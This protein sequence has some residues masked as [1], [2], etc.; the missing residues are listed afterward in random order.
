MYKRLAKSI[1]LFLARFS[2]VL[3]IVAPLFFTKGYL[4]FTDLVWG[5]NITLNWSNS[6]F[7]LNSVIKG[8]SFILSV[9]LIEKIYITLCLGLVL[10]GGRKIA[11]LF[12]KNQWL[13]FIASLFAFFNPFVYDRAM[14]GQINIVGA[15]GLMLLGAGFLFEY[16]AVSSTRHSKTLPVIPAKAGTRDA[17]PFPLDPGF[18]RDDKM[19]TE[20]DGEKSIKQIFFAGLAFAFS[21][22]FS[23]HFIFFIAAFYILVFLPMFFVG[24]HGSSVGI[25]PERSRRT[26]DDKKGMFTEIIKISVIIAVI[27][28][29][30]NANWIIG[31][32]TGKSA[33]GEFI[34]SGITTQ[35]LVAFQT[36][37]KTG[38]DAL[39]NVLMMSGF[40]GKDQFRYAD[41]TAFA[42]NWGRSFFFLLPLVLWGFVAGLRSKEKKYKYL[43]VGS[44]VLFVVSVILAAGIR[45]PVGRELTYFLFNHLPFYK[46]LRESQKWVSATA[47]IYLIFLSLGLRELFSKKF[48]QRH[49][50]V[51]KCFIGAVIV[52]QAPL[53]L[54]GFGGQ[55]TPVQY[56]NDWYAVNDY[57]VH[58][59]GCAGTTLFFPWH[60]YMSFSW[61]GRI[62]ANPAPV[63]FQCPV[64]SGTDMEFGGI[65]DN[66]E[67]PEGRAVVAWLGAGG[68]TDLLQNS[69]WNIRYV[70]LAKELD[71]KSYVGMDF[72]PALKLVMDT[73]TLRVYKVTP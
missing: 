34:S 70:I 52:M 58:D 33:M 4:F 5:P 9:D 2:P 48:I 16:L 46:G 55:V 73:A 45:I 24:K 57:I 62:V 13:V 15:F 56:P 38:A 40:W 44:A 60:M 7:L 8:L 12:L 32:A 21:T 59:S 28:L 6:S 66:S 39:G 53:L 63:F 65:Y 37:G 49:A 61:L 23:P 3:F 26:D 43:T 41:L 36:A 64:V 47:A 11:G 72:N 31:G 27:A 30:L 54:F 50:L 10:W 20:D 22:Q 42:N 67:N 17:F 14:Y 69:A 25:Y 68:R 35:D 19:K 29:A 71:W 1:L 51:M 18:R